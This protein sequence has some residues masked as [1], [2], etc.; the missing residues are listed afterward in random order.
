MSLFTLGLSL[1]PPQFDD[2]E[3][4]HQ[5]TQF[6]VWWQGLLVYDSGELESDLLEHE[7]VIPDNVRGVP[8]GRGEQIFYMTYRVRGSINGWTHWAPLKECFVSLG[9][10]APTAFEKGPIESHVTVLGLDSRLWRLEIRDAVYM[11]REKEPPEIGWRDPEHMFD[12]PD[13]P[14]NMHD[15]SFTFDQLGRPVVFYEVSGFIKGYFYNPLEGTYGVWDVGAG[16]TPRAK[17]DYRWFSSLSDAEIILFYIRGDGHLC[18]RLQ[19]DRYQDEYETGLT[20]FENR[21]LKQLDNTEDHRLC[22]TYIEEG[23]GL[24]S[25]G[26]PDNPCYTFGFCVSDEYRAHEGMVD[27]SLTIDSKLNHGSRR[28]SLHNYELADEVIQV[29]GKLVSGS[30]REM[31]WLSTTSEVLEVES[32]LVHGSRRVALFIFPDPEQPYLPVEETTNPE[33]LSQTERYGLEMLTVE[34]SMGTATRRRAIIQMQL[35]YPYS[36]KLEIQASLVG[37]SRNVPD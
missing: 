6:R 19:S 31:L 18:Y 16:R 36:N 35:Y 9:F 14:E 32:E 22:L 17:L 4:T 33:T 29:V 34:A 24:G 15:L 3:E 7:A 21:Y 27:Y 28:V 37:G 12:P 23:P 30:R 2:P 1:T 26:G 25:G 11:A 13:S 10:K 20:G 5:A 8:V